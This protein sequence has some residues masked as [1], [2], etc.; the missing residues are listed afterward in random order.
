MFGEFSQV[1]HV[2]W[3]TFELCFESSLTPVFYGPD[4]AFAQVARVPVG[5][6]TTC[7]K[8]LL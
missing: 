4:H 7:G 3:L 5:S 6:S 1:D 8:D 2:L